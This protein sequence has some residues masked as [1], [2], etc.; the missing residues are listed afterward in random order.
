MVQKRDDDKPPKEIAALKRDTKSRKQLEKEIIQFL[1]EASTKQG[2]SKRPEEAVL[3]HGLGCVLAT[4]KDNIPRATPVDFFNDGL[5]LWVA[6]EPGVKIRNLQ[7]NPQIAVGIYQPMNPLKL[8]RSLQIQG[9]A[10]LI[11]L[12]Q[13]RRTFMKCVKKL[14]LLTGVERIVGRNIQSGRVPREREKEWVEKLL[15]RFNLIRID[16]EEIT[17]LYIHPNKGAEK[18]TWRKYIRSGKHR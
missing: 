16:P 9:K 17:Y 11:N 7:S 14:G 1:S 2:T 13:H 10:T 15:N 12:R 3:K 4:A 8:N 5:T 18:N 6:G